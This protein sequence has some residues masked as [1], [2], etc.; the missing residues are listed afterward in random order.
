MGRPP[1]GKVAMTG[2]ERV[3]RYRLKHGA[4]KPVTK[5]VTK[6]AREDATRWQAE[7]AALKA[8][9][10]RLRK[11]LTESREDMLA[12]T[13]Q[14]RDELK[15]RAAKPKAEKPPLS[16]DEARDRRIKA[17]A[18]EVRN[19]KGQLRGERLLHSEALLRVGGMS[20]ATM[21]AIA[22][23][24]HPDRESTAA[25]RDT[26]LKLFTAWK[27]DSHKARRK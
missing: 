14:F 27:S 8:E 19:L 5:P 9:N 10:E 22:K 4:D 23:A 12:Q 1:I 24:L 11:E 26:A 6:P 18:A 20:F 25:E 13:V 3:R 15:R 21:S 16:P 7:V 2:A 17:L